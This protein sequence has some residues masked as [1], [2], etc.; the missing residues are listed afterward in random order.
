MNRIGLAIVLGIGA[1][2]G[3]IFGVWP[4]LDLELAAPFFDADKREFV[5]ASNPVLLA[6]A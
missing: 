1:T 4:Q 6:P 5:R 3:L 2:V